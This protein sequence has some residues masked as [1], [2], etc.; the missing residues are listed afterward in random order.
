MKCWF[1]TGEWTYYTTIVKPTSLS[2]GKQLFYFYAGPEVGNPTVLHPLETK[3]TAL[4]PGL[5]FT[6]PL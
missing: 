1:M 3:E 6:T 2:V 4:D 5:P